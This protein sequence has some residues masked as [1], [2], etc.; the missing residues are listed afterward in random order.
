[1]KKAVRSSSSNLKSEARSWGPNP[2]AISSDVIRCTVATRS[3]SSG[4]RTTIHWKPYSSPLRVTSEP[5]SAAAASSSSFRSRS[6]AANSPAESGLKQTAAAPAGFR[7]S[8]TSRVTPAVESANRR[9][10][11][12]SLSCLLPKR[13]ARRPKPLRD[14]AAHLAGDLGEALEPLLGRRV[15][16]EELRDAL[17]DVGRHDEEGVHRLDLP[18][19]A[20]RDPSHV[21]RDALERA[22]Q[23]LRS[24]RDDRRAAVGR[25]LAVARDGA[26][27]QEAEHVGHE[28]G[29]QDDK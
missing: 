7:P 21:A 9:S 3:S 18:Q 4:S 22:H 29:D 20:L 8:S 28:R 12:A 16:R 11:E 13:V 19:V 10:G 5:E 2:L 23:V 26:D 6:A 27:E 25:E 17:A 1:M 15:R 14:R 24:P